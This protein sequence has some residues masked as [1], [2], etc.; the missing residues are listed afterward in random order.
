MAERKLNLNAPLLSVR[1][2][3][4]PVRAT[5]VIKESKIVDSKLDRITAHNADSSLELVT[6]PVAVPFNWEQIPGRRK[7]ACK[8]ELLRAREGSVTSPRF[9]I[10]WVPGIVKNQDDKR[11]KLQTSVTLPKPSSALNNKAAA[12]DNG[13][14]DDDDDDDDDKYSDALESL[15]GT[16][17]CSMKCSVSGVSSSSDC[18]AVGKPSGTFSTD[19]QTRDFM[20]NRFLPAAKA[21]AL[22]QSHHATT[23]KQSVAVEPQPRQIV[24]AARGDS[25]PNVRRYESA[26]VPYYPPKDFG[27]EGSEEE[28]DECEDES[29]N[30][31]TKACGF[32][33]RLCFKNSVGLLNPVPGM[34]VRSLPSLSCSTQKAKKPSKAAPSPSR[35]ISPFSRKSCS[36]DASRQ[37][38][39][40][41]GAHS[42]RLAEVVNKLNSGSDSFNNAHDRQ[43]AGRISPF[44]R[45]SGGLSPYRNSAPQSPFRG[46]G[47]SKEAEMFKAS[48]PYL[49]CKGGSKSQELTPLHRMKQGASLVNLNP[50]TNEKTLYVDT[51]SVPSLSKRTTTPNPVRG[52]SQALVCITG[53]ESPLP[54]PKTPSESWL[55]RTLP[56][57]S[58]RNSID[59]GTSFQNKWLDSKSSKWETMVKSSYMHHDH[60]R[61]SEELIPQHLKI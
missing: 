38:S 2:F 39:P 36:K 32:F 37:Q 40:S 49:Y 25:S 1:R 3:S 13:N 15:S 61:Y 4:S 26:L 27:M 16:D 56:A 9:P 57:A 20:M 24:M 23:K 53:N 14:V 6:E 10:R 44:S 28:G 5:E 29:V 8:T 30:L 52:E 55:W 35:S 47:L 18:A 17:S 31:P 59:R 48:R 51:S 45:R 21:M 41:R 58:A 22:E 50:P 42:P 46:A 12:I 11:L 60:V 33:P 43:M 19:P 54:L 34:K 7:D